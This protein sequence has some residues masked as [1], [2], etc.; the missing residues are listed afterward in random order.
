MQWQELPF[1]GSSLMTGSEQL[2]GTP[3]GKV[4]S[5]D[6]PL[7]GTA[8]PPFLAESHLPEDSH[9]HSCARWAWN[10]GS[11]QNER[12]GRPW[13]T[14]SPECI[15]RPGNPPDFFFCV[16]CWETGDKV[17]QLLEAVINSSQLPSNIF[18]SF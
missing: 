6:L 10:T 8:N 2:P 17:S 11:G 1:L 15:Q 9:F 3:V 7:P 14:K 13:C 5:S 16:N 4:L 18:C 12:R